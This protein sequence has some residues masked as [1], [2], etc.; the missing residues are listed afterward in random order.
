MTYLA[1]KTNGLQME[2]LRLVQEHQ[3]DKTSHF[4]EME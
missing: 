4:G 2:S 3:T 1:Q